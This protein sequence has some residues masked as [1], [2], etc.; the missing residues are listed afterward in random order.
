M[1]LCDMDSLLRYN[2]APQVEAFST[3]RDAELPYYVVQPHQVHGC[4]IREVV[5]PLTPRSALEGVDAL[6][7]NVPVL[8]FM[9]VRPIV[10]R[11]CCM[12][13]CIRQLRLFMTVGGGLSSGSVLW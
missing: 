11:C 7:T 10:F 1:Y 2:I 8:R 3:C 4:Q 9:Y 6:V 5:D 13:L 12:T